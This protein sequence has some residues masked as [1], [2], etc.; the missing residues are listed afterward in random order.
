MFKRMV[1]NFEKSTPHN[2]RRTVFIANFVVV[3][4]IIAFVAVLVVN[5]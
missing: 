5:A 3:G 4:I 2:Q 1:E